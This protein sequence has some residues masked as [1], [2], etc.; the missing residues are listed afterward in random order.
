MQLA[1]H[2]GLRVVAI[3]GPQDE[4]LVRDLG[5]EWFV[6]RSDDP[7]GAVRAVVPGGVDGVFDPALLG[8]PALAAVRDGGSYLNAA[9]PLAPAPERGITTGGVSVHSDGA[10]LAELVRLV[11]SGVLT[12]RVADTYAFEDAGHGAR[13]ARQGWRTRPAGLRALIGVSG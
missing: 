8:A 3:A 1:A 5:A 9:S 7:A 11:E 2:R 13:V 4:Q 6:A 12:L 10:E